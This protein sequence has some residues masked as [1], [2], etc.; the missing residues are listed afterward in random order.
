LDNNE[1]EGGFVMRK[2]LAA[3]VLSLAPLG[4]GGC[5]DPLS[6]AVFIGSEIAGGSIAFGGTAFG[7]PSEDEMAKKMAY[8]DALKATPS[9][10]LTVVWSDPDAGGP[11]RERVLALVRENASANA[12]ARPAYAHA[13]VIGDT[14]TW[15][16]SDNASGVSGW[17]KITYNSE[18]K[19][20]ASHGIALHGQELAARSVLRYTQNGR[21]VEVAGSG[22]DVAGAEKPIG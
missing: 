4:L 6:G 10:I 19:Q 7:T 22:K 21:W 17:V 12:A 13:S 18:G 16:W 9:D 20:V 11:N 2:L 5:T 3:V 8:N 14:G 15:N 1:P